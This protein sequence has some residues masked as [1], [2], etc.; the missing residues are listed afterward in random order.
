VIFLFNDRFWEVF[1]RVLDET[2]RVMVNI[3]TV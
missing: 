2:T 1:S 3:V